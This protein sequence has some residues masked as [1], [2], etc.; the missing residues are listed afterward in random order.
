MRN[1]TL[2]KITVGIVVAFG[3]ALAVVYTG[4]GELDRLSN[5]A[6]QA[7]NYGEAKGHLEKILK[8]FRK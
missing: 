3:I 2:L 1:N 7:N 4:Y 8:I 6:I 5:L